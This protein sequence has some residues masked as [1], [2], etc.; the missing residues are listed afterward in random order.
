MDHQALKILEDSIGIQQAQ[1]LIILKIIDC[2]SN[3]LECEKDLLN[4]ILWRI[5]NAALLKSVKGVLDT[6]IE[7][8]K[9]EHAQ[10]SDEFKENQRKLEKLRAEL[11]DRRTLP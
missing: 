6:R 7:E 10:L 9:T 3:I 8:L 2:K 5:Q 11:S 1:D 4:P